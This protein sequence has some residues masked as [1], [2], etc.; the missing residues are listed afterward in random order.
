MPVATESL[1]T[2]VP[3]GNRI[4]PRYWLQASD[5]FVRS[6]I[7]I[8]PE[9][10]AWPCGPAGKCSRHFRD[11]PLR[12]HSGLGPPP[13]YVPTG[14][15][16]ELITLFLSRV[17]FL[18]SH[19]VSDLVFYFIS[20]MYHMHTRLCLSLFKTF[21]AALIA[22]VCQ[23]YIITPLCLLL[24]LLFSFFNNFG[25][26]ENS[27]IRFCQG[28]NYMTLT[29]QI[30]FACHYLALG[31]FTWQPSNCVTSGNLEPRSASSYLIHQVS[32]HNTRK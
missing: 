26:S 16:Y 5:D 15:F 19:F 18:I 24:V 17:L 14:L 25:S 32:V 6:S 3:P 28:F 10:E 23:Y 20:C 1:G 22:D 8:L 13:F 27:L 31:Q 9:A 12:R 4:L 11:C 7:I 21:F 2:W 29:Q 30:S